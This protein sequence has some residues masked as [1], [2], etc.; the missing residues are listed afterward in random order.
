MKVFKI[1]EESEC[2]KAGQELRYRIT[3]LKVEGTLKRLLFQ[4]PYFS[5]KET[6]VHESE[7]L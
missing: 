6:E 7:D 5:D 4:L 3:D 1:K 2:V